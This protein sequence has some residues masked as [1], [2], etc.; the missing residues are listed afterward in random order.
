[1][2]ALEAEYGCPNNGSIAK[3]FRLAFGLHGQPMQP[4]YRIIGLETDNPFVGFDDEMAEEYEAVGHGSPVTEATDTTWFFID[5][6]PIS[7]QG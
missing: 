1:M 6:A 2:H 4:A 3:D 5:A 7:T